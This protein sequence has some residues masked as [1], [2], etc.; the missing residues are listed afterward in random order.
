M[1][2]LFQ[3]NREKYNVDPKAFDLPL[4]RMTLNQQRDAYQHEIQQLKEENIQLGLEVKI[5]IPIFTSLMII[6]L[7]SIEPEYQTSSATRE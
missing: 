2:Q 7:I 3:P 6:Y 5:V 1:Q 4:K